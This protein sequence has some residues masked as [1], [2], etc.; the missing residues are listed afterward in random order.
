MQDGV[1]PTREGRALHDAL[2]SA[3]GTHG[4]YYPW[5]VD[6]ARWVVTLHLFGRWKS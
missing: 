4:G 3:F 6:H 1:G 2:R 5:A